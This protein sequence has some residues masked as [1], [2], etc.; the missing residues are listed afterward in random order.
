MG[1]WIAAGDETGNWDIVD[2]SFGSSYTGLAWVLAKDSSWAQALA[3]A[4]GETTA[5]DAFSRTFRSR[6]P[7]CAD[8]PDAGDKYHVKDVWDYC[9]KRGLATEIPLDVPQDDPVLEMLRGDAL[10]L[11]SRSGLSVLAAGGDAEDARAAGLLDSGDG[12]RERAR[13][14]AALMML[15]LPFLPGDDQVLLQPEGRTEVLIA[16]AAKFNLFSERT[17]DTRGFEPYRNFVDHLTDDLARAARRC[18][19]VVSGGEVVSTFECRKSWEIANVVRNARQPR[20]SAETAKVAKAINGI[21]DLAAALIANP[22]ARSRL[23]VPAAMAGNVWTGNYRQ[24]GEAI[25]G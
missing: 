13:A 6:L 16:Q 20:L 23:V 1:Y 14:F 10:W 21:A 7:E 25:H 15:A 24:L 2:G 11:I 22:A 4:H 19:E 12:L 9:S 17:S 8:L 3:S 18:K 5:L